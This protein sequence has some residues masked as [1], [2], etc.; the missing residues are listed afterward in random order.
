MEAHLEKLE[1]WE[2]AKLCQVVGHEQAQELMQKDADEIIRQ[3]RTSGK[4]FVWRWNKG[5]N[6][7]IRML[8]REGI[9]CVRMRED[10]KTVELEFK[11]YDVSK[12]YYWG[13]FLRVSSQPQ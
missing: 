2:L 6:R 9:A 10:Y 13:G 5:I 12:T 1:K 3:F 7:A 4:V 8:N 11:E